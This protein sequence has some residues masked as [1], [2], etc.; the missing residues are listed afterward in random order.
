[1]GFSFEDALIDRAKT[2]CGLETE[3]E[4]L[5][6]AA[7]LGALRIPDVTPAEEALI[8]CAGGLRDGLAEGL[9]RDIGR[10]G[11]PLG[12]PSRFCGHPPIAGNGALHILP[13]Q[14]SKPW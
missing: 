4:V 11:D 1:M 8:R 6:A 14:L 13:A 2:R 9:K 10:N 5:A 12:P 3:S 7:A